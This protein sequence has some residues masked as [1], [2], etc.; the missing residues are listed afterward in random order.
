MNEKSSGLNRLLS[1]YNYKI[2]H[3]FTLL[4]D[5]SKPLEVQFSYY[6]TPTSTL[7]KLKNTIGEKLN[8]L[9]LGLFL[10]NPN[11]Q[12]LVKVLSLNELDSKQKYWVKKRHITQ[13]VL[14][15]LVLLTF[16]I[17]TRKPRHSQAQLGTAKRSN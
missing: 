17:I 13:E 2:E 11:N 6:H 4:E 3:I 1:D 15:L 7:E 9:V 14:L 10:Y 5:Y 12:D 16:R 8:C